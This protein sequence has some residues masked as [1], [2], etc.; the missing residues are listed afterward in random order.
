MQ[1]TFILLACALLS[2]ISFTIAI[3]LDCRWSIFASPGTTIELNNLDYIN[4][5]DRTSIQWNYVTGTINFTFYGD[6]DASRQFDLCFAH[7][8]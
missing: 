4:C 8:S 6:K 7:I 2:I 3:P 5:T 1:K